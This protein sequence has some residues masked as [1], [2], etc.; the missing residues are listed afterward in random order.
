MKKCLSFKYLP[1]GTNVLFMVYR[2]LI[3]ILCTHAIIWLNSKFCI[4]HKTVTPL[5]ITQYGKKNIFSL[6]ML[7]TKKSSTVILSS[8]IVSTFVKGIQL[9]STKQ[10]T[11]KYEQ[12]ANRNTHVHG[13]YSIEQQYIC[14]S[15]VIQSTTQFCL[16]NFMKRIHV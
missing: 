16:A 2:C 12:N 10:I 3:W 4:L 11:Q 6:Q 14:I 13:M 1:M 9:P 7:L 5:K 15:A 8:R